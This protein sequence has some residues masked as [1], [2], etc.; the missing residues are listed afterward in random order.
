MG[1]GG[2]A[3]LIQAGTAIADTV[4]SAKAAKRQ[5]KLERETFK[6]QSLLGAQATQAL[7]IETQRAQA[8]EESRRRV[9]NLLGSPGSYD[10]PGAA[11]G[12]S[13]VPARL[14]ATPAFSA[15]LAG[16]SSRRS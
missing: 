8:A 9:F 16:W 5:Y 4:L 1:A 12:V 14:P 2:A 13:A 6:K 11:P 7:D 3:A 15:L 10:L